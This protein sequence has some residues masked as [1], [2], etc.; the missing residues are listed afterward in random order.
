MKCARP[1]S[2]NPKSLIVAPVAVTFEILKIG[3]PSPKICGVTVIVGGVEKGVEKVIVKSL[4]VVPWSWEIVKPV[5]PAIESVPFS[6]C[7]V[8]RTK[9]RSSPAGTPPIFSICR[10]Q[11]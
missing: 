6:K 10:K 11:D 5:P 2:M 3:T 7:T 9:D 4:P 1:G 8:P